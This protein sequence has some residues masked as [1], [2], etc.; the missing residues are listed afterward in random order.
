MRGGDH[1]SAVEAEL[2]DGEVEHLGPNEAY[3]HHVGAALPSAADRRFGNR[4]RRQ[5]RVSPHGQGVQ[6][7]HLDE[8]SPDAAGAA[9]VDRVGVDAPEVVRLENLRIERHGRILGPFGLRRSHAD[10]TAA[11][12][13]RVSSSTSGM[14][15]TSARTGMKFVSP[16]QRGTTCRWTWS[17]TPAPAIRPRFQPRLKPWGL[18]VRE[19][20]SSP[21]VASRCTSTTSSSA[22]DPRS[23]VCRRGATIRWPDAYGNLLRTT[24]ARAPRWTTSPVASSAST[25]TQKMQP[26]CSS[27]AWMYSSR[28][29]AQSRRTARLYHVAPGP[30][31]LSRA[32]V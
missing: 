25:A 3:V 17:T 29:G 5:T 30:S 32:R 27:A 15:F 23:A 22:S 6:V 1:D 11:S 19:R 24:T 4:R 12:F 13:S 7:E 9:L 21:L 31:S 28:Q 18:I 20:A 14:T 2:R 10:H 16:A 8:R 26:G